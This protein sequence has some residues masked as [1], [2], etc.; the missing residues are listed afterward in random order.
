MGKSKTDGNPNS[1]S[2]KLDLEHLVKK[3]KVEQPDF[4]RHL[5]AL[6]RLSL[7]NNKAETEGTPQLPLK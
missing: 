1:K 4:Y 6:I 5:V 2:E 7:A 3:I